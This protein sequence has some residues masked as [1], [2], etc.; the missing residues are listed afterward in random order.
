MEWFPNLTCGYEVG[1][2]QEVKLW[3]RSPLTTCFLFVLCNTDWRWRQGSLVPEDADWWWT[4]KYQWH[5]IVWLPPRGPHP[6]QRLLQ[7][8]QADCQE[9]RHRH[10]DHWKGL[11]HY[12]QEDGYFI[13]AKLCRQLR[14]NGQRA[15][16]SYFDPVITLIA[17]IHINYS[18][19]LICYSEDSVTQNMQGTSELRG[20]SLFS[21]TTDLLFKYHISPEI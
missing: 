20:F 7:D 2:G 9:V 16:G 10:R 15:F 6:H 4:G 11:C 1:R 14:Q 21:V 5:S 12:H 17:C 3:G 13:W 19:E 8:P 18:S